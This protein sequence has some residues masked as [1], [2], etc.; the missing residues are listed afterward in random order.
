[1]HKVRFILVMIVSLCALILALPAFGQDNIAFTDGRINNSDGAAPIALYCEDAGIV[2]Y[3]INSGGS[4]SPVLG[5]TYNGLRTALR[6]AIS[7]RRNVAVVRGGGSTLYALSSNELQVVSPTSS[8]G[9]YTFI[10]RSNRCGD[11]NL[12]AIT[13]QSQN[14][15]P[16]P[17]NPLANPTSGPNTGTNQ[18]PLVPVTPGPGQQT[19]I[20]QYGETLFRIALRYGL[21]TQALAQANA[22]SNVNLIYAGQTLIIPAVP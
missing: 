16:I 3:D 22:I 5:V 17:A 8:G 4:G 10:F 13:R 7:S 6:E 11:L 19:H 9:N 14:Q 15:S 21:T 2:G 1:M 18:P 20:V 12:G